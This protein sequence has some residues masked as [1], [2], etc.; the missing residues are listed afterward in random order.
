MLWS[1]CGAQC[2]NASRETIFRNWQMLFC[3]NLLSNFTK[4]HGP[5]LQQGFHAS[6]CFHCTVSCVVCK[7][8]GRWEL[9]QPTIANLVGCWILHM[10]EGGCQGGTPTPPYLPF[11]R[12]PAVK[13]VAPP[14]PPGIVGTCWRQERDMGGSPEQTSSCPSGLGP[15]AWLHPEHLWYLWLR[16][17]SLLYSH[18][19]QMREPEC[20]SVSKSLHVSVKESVHELVREFASHCVSVCLSLC[21]NLCMSQY[22]SAWIRARVNAW[23]TVCSW[24]SAVVHVR[25]GCSDGCV[26]EVPG[27]VA[28]FY[29]HEQKDLLALE[30]LHSAFPLRL[31]RS[32]RRHFGKSKLRH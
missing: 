27:S 23:L 2:N 32:C 22:E 5:C 28:G 9:S 21:A 1:S 17:V 6:P 11:Q 24:V 31:V 26:C 29:V 14:P 12:R 18:W 4:D 13:L 10:L 20:G 7:G 19:G 30:L 3:V 8:C 15:S 25:V 16:W